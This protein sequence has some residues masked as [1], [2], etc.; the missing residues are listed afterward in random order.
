MENEYCT[1]Y[2]HVPVNKP[3]SIPRYNLIPLATASGPGQSFFDSY[4][5]SSDD[6]E[7]FIPDNVAETTPGQ[8]DCVALTFSAARLYLNSLPEAPNNWGQSN[9]N[10]DDYHRDPMEISSTLWIPDMTDWRR[11]LQELHSKYANVSDVA[12][13]IFSI[14][15]HGVGVEGS[16]PLGRDD[17]SWRQSTT[18]GET[19]RKEV[20]VRQLAQPKQRHL[21]RQLPSIWYKKH[22]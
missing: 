21:S 9:P 4:D 12:Q 11:Q 20:V 1:A 6:E 22:R 13:D 16:F 19:L 2:G 5:L 17:T 18:A 7:G 14:I 10:L 3:D 15:P 8:R